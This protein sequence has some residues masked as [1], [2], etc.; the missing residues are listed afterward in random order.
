MD[1]DLFHILHEHGAISIQDWSLTLNNSISFSIELRNQVEQINKQTN[2]KD[3]LFI[4]T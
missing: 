3:I 4:C 2:K 1:S